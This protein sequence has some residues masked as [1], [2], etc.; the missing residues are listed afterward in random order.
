MAKVTITIED[1]GD[2]IDVK[3]VFDPPL[4]RD[5]DCTSAQ[6]AAFHMLR[7]LKAAIKGDADDE[8]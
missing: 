7:S 8:S 4:E 2:M 6:Q 5:A 3:N 1:D